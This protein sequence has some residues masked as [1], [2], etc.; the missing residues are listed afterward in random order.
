MSEEIKNLNQSSI[1]LNKNSKGYTFS[2]KVYDYSDD[3][4]LRRL[5]SLWD[6]VEAEVKLRE[7]LHAKEGVNV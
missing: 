2:L 3:E 6:S 7:E 5:K 4:M 1:E